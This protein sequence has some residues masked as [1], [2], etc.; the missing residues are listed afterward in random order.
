M[1][2]EVMYYGKDEALPELVR[3]ETADLGPVKFVFGAVRTGEAGNVIPAHAE[4]RASVRTSSV[5]LWAQLPDIVCRL[6]RQVV[7]GTGADGDVDYIPGIPPVRNDEHVTE[8]VAAG[9]AEALAGHEVVEAPQSWG[10]DDFA[11]DTQLV[12]GTYVRLGTHDPDD[13]G[14]RLDLHAGHFDVDERSI[15]VGVR[16]MVAAAHQL[17]T[18]SDDG[19]R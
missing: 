9:L 16:M 7:E 14:P 4:L 3:A 10:A 12:P 17:L 18:W 19:P 2:T 6:A 5:E 15:A 11:W 8:V 13:Q 1:K